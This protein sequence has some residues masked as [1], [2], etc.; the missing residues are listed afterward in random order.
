MRKLIYSIIFSIICGIAFGQQLISNNSFEL[1][2]DSSGIFTTTGDYVVNSSCG[3][4]SGQGAP[5]GWTATNQTP[6]RLK[7][8]FG[9]C[10]WD[11]NPAQDGDYYCVN[12]NSEGMKSNLLYALDVGSTYELRYF[13]KLET[14]HGTAGDTAR[15]SFSFLSPAGNVINSP[16]INSTLIWFQAVNIFT[17]T[18]P[19]TVIEIKS[20]I[21]GAGYCIDNVTLIKTNPLFVQWINIWA[22]DC[23]LNWLVNEVNNSHFEVYLARE[24]WEYVG[25]VEG[26]GNAQNSHY[27][28][29]IVKSG[30]YRIKSV[31]IDGKSQYSKI[32][33][34]RRKE[35][36][37][38]NVWE[39]I[40]LLGREIR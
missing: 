9:S 40:D 29:K 13:Y 11:S 8:N 22:T 32:L 14:L 23:C 38:Y 39:F 10:V 15:I 31:D 4:Y 35:D 36:E 28:I 24:E 26:K 6:D 16:I 37:G 19:S 33:F 1:G 7:E 25:R 12:G 20:I 18:Q 17:A 30:Y 27:H 21:N 2:N 3:T 34:V 5:T